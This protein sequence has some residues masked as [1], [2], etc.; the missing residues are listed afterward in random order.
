M[1]PFREPQAE[2]RESE[3]QSLCSASS[4]KKP[5][6]NVAQQKHT[7]STAMAHW[8][9]SGGDNRKLPYENPDMCC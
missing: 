8:P 1:C 5:G 6:A 9:E 7:I 3:Q 4:A 2:V